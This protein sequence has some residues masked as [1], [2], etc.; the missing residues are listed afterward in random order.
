MIDLRSRELP[1]SIEVGGIFYSLNTDFRI[2]IEFG[3]QLETSGI[4]IRDV[5][6]GKVPP[7]RDGLDAVIEFYRSENVTPREGGD[8]PT[9]RAID[10]VLDGDYIV[11]SFQQAY[12]IDLTSIDYMHWH[13]FKALLNG[14]PKDTIL[15]RAISYRMWRPTNRKH[16]EI[17]REERKRWLL[18]L[19][20]DEQAEQELVE[21]AEQ[22][23][24][25]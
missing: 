1:S 21:W 3:H 8:V 13:R 25:N 20:K 24:L 16:E 23:G 14:L 17:M 2:W 7:G 18:P 9:T 10:L 22:L 12:G 15:A 11:A 4:A 5:F 6:A 19:P